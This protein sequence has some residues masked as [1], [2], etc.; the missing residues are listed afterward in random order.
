MK[1]EEESWPCSECGEQ[2]QEAWC[3]WSI[4]VRVRVTGTVEER[5]VCLA[6]EGAPVKGLNG[7]GHVYILQR[8]CRLS[9]EAVG[10]EGLEW[11]LEAC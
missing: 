6:G 11:R 8:P 3:G 9:V 5:G 4:S 2:I 1:D 10:L 7:T